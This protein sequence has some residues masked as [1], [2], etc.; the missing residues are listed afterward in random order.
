MSETNRG[1]TPSQDADGDETVSS[2]TK[3][4]EHY[5]DVDDS[6]VAHLSQSLF[7]SLE[8]LDILVDNANT[9]MSGDIADTPYAQQD[10][11]EPENYASNEDQVY[12]IL[13]QLKQDISDIKEEQ[14][15]QHATPVE[16]PTYEIVAELRRDIDDIRGENPLPLTEND[17]QLQ[18]MLNELRRDINEIKHRPDMSNVGNTEGQLYNA[19]SEMQRDIGSLKQF[20]SQDQIFDSRGGGFTFLNLVKLAVMGI[21]AGLTVVV[22]EKT[23]DI[24]ASR[25]GVMTTRYPEEF[26]RRV[27]RAAPVRTKLARDIVGLAGTPISLDIDLSSLPLPPGSNVKISQLPNT[28]V[29]SSGQRKA[30]DW[31]VPVNNIDGLTMLVPDSYNGFVNAQ[32]EVLDNAGKII[33]RDLFRVTIVAKTEQPAA[34]PVI[35]NEPLQAEI[36]ALGSA[37]EKDLIANANSLLDQGDVVGA[38]RVL[39]FAISQGSVTAAVALARTYD[40]KIVSEMTSLFGV[41]PDI[42]RAKVLYYFAAR[43]GNK[44]AAKRLTEISEEQE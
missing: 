17:A 35:R 22:L 37:E 43:K 26:D 39:D 12:M 7:A 28:A 9:S 18:A 20:Q 16:Q 10:A 25:E 2:N 8:S 6:N 42:T 11:N 36:P 31:L 23:A 33:R 38:R 32:I 13:S 21:V 14:A 5:E 41:K 34:K 15:Y 40:P 3:D 44:E 29:L 19:L 4:E 30:K 27:R 24:A 1:K